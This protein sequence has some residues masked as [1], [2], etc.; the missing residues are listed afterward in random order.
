MTSPCLPRQGASRRLFLRQ[1]A[2]L[3]GLGAAAPLA[4]NLSAL[5][6][7][8]AQ[9]A[10]DYKA[11]VC[12]FLFG[13]NDSMNMVL[14]TDADSWAHYTAVRTQA[15]DAIALM[16]PGTPPLT[17][18]AAGSPARLGGVLPIAPANPQGRSFA[19]HPVMGTLQTMFDQDRRLAIVPNVGPLIVP[20]TKAQ[21]A[22]SQHPKPANL[23]SHNDQANFWQ[24]FQ[25]EGAREGW[26]GRMADLLASQNERAVFTAIST[27]GN[28]VW[29]S[30][31]TVRQYQ[32]GGNGAVRMGTAG[33]ANAIWGYPALGAALGRIATTA[34]GTHPFERD[35]AALNAR[36]IDAE[37]A[38]RT[39][40]KDAGDPRFGT[41]GVSPDPKLQYTSPLTG[42]KA[43]NILAQ[44]LQTVARMIDACSTEGLR[45]R[46]QV[47]FVSL[48]GFD[49]HDSQ[50]RAHADLYARL[51]HGL[52]YFDDTLAAMGRQQ[53]VTTF[54][55]SDFGRSF[56]SNGDGTD[57]GWGAHHFVMGG[58]VKGGDLYGRFPILGDR[59]PATNYFDSSPD[60]VGNGALLPETSVDQLGATLA[61]WFGISDSDALTVFPHLASFS[62]RDLGFMRA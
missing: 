34:R 18:A 9:S 29:L 15:P 10:S 58:A 61:R 31:Q 59:N 54:T 12:V 5:G 19:L 37:E 21:Y 27:S 46:R 24:A 17:S 47:F 39:A 6:S 16:A 55:A 33:S 56:T 51:A 20:T 49:T 8:A 45:A 41:P 7:A 40:L 3:A 53:Q 22:S 42:A 52:R 44:Q 25:P 23:F 60:Q 26:G 14:P 4:L 50:N 32:V 62:V 30:G 1:A 28:A 48:G 43:T 35:L 57:H 38:L 2:S 36:S 11:L 13:G